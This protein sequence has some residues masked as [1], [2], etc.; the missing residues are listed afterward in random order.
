MRSRDANFSQ[1]DWSM[2]GRLNGTDEAAAADALERLVRRY[3]PAVYAFIRRTGRDV[4]QASDLTQAFVADVVLRRGLI[5]GADPAR[6]RFRHLLQAALR[7]FLNETERHRLRHKRTPVGSRLVGLDGSIEP[8]ST[9]DA[10]S[11]EHAFDAAWC[12]T[13]VQGVLQRVQEECK[14]DALG[15]HWAVFEARVVQPVLH[16]TE[17]V[18]FEEISRRLG[19]SGAAQAANLLVTIKRRFLRALRAEIAATV[20]DDGQVDAELADILRHIDG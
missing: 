16:G 6:G 5:H 7:N 20:S 9:A 2:I 8:V 15:V 10:D 11:P 14:R 18:P 19:L 4:H 12:R 13:L 1:T 17:P 3:W